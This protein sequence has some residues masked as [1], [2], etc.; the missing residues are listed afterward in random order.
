MS[1]LELQV[2]INQVDE[3]VS[4]AREAQAVARSFTQQQIDDVVRAVGWACYQLDHATELAAHSVRETGIGSEADRVQKI[5]RKALMMMRDLADAPSVGILGINEATKLTEI[6]KPVGVVAAICPSTHPATDLMAKA[7]MILKGR[8]AV[9]ISAS[10][11]GIETS[12]LACQYIREEVDRV[13]APADLVQILHRPSKAAAIELMAQCD[14]VAVTGSARNVRAAYESGTPTFAGGAGNVPIIIEPSA[15]LASTAEM[16]ARSKT[17]DYGTACSSESELLIQ[18]SVYDEMLSN[19]ISEGGHLLT[20]AQK[21]RLAHVLWPDGKINPK[22][23]GRSARAIADEAQIS[24][25]DGETS[26]PFFIVEEDGVGPSYPFSGE[27]L[28]V[29]VAAY[30][31]SGYYDALR[32]AKDILA[33]QGAGH[34]CGIHTADMGHAYELAES[35]DVARVIVNQ[36]QGTAEAGSFTNGLPATM[37]LGCG[38]WGGNNLSG[39][40]TYEH[41]INRTTLA[42]P[43]PERIPSEDELWGEYLRTYYA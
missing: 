41:F 20:E 27:K 6:A 12:E 24:L 22:M 30:R 2:D 34:S 16:I 29:T 39:N 14:M 17:F 8:N 4:R 36:P 9:V 43:L 31:Y 1:T 11:G 3:A 18:E 23:V 19:L 28:S 35:M 26:T 25:R 37:I 38:T 10:P 5:R 33:H 32:L 15:D 42:E 13:G 21:E 7:M 40:V